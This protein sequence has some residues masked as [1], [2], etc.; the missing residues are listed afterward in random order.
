MK[1]RST[2]S[3][4]WPWGEEKGSKIRRRH[5]DKAA[6]PIPLPFSST[7]SL[8]SDV[9]LAQT[10]VAFSSSFDQ[11]S[12]GVF[13][14]SITVTLEGLIDVDRSCEE[15]SV[16]HKIANTQRAQTRLP[17]FSLPKQAFLLLRS[18]SALALD[19]IC[20]WKLFSFSLC[21]YSQWSK[22]RIL[23]TDK[24]LYRWDVF[25]KMT[26]LR[27]GD[28]ALD[29]SELSVFQRRIQNP[30]SKSHSPNTISIA[31]DREGED[32][33]DQTHLSTRL[34]IVSFLI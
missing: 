20:N 4:A 18:P 28:F 32:A 17:N 6:K 24:Q 25:R 30:K 26:L 7:L 22:T 11:S 1:L 34:L 8:D 9:W 21:P 29:T 10:L 15:R 27:C 5:M 33:E 23:E 2:N 19:P 16:S 31:R 13:F 14:V 12:S 3:L